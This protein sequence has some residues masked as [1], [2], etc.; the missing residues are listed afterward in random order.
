M[1]KAWD[2]FTTSLPH[3]ATDDLLVFP[4]PPSDF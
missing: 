1:A 2:S 4:G 3:P